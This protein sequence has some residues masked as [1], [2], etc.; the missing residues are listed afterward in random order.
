VAPAILATTCC[1]RCVLVQFELEKFGLSCRPHQDGIT[2]RLAPRNWP[3]GMES[4]WF[5]ENAPSGG[6]GLTLVGGRIRM[7]VIARTSYQLAGERSPLG[8]GFSI[9]GKTNEESFHCT[10]ARGCRTGGVVAASPAGG[11]PDGPLGAARAAAKNETQSSF[12]A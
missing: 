11:G 7:T 6:T 3:A 4:G 2:H 5:G 9:R 1:V 8:P 12:R 10:V